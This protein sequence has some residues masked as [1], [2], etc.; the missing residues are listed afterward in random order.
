VGPDAYTRVAVAPPGEPDCTLDIVEVPSVRGKG[1]MRGWWFLLFLALLRFRILSAIIFRLRV[2]GVASFSCGR[3]V[4]GDVFAG[5]R[6]AEGIAAL[7]A[8]SVV[9]CRTRSLPFP[10]PFFS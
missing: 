10:S 3:L 8:S 1:V 7:L 4:V 6:R 5:T 9:S 2:D